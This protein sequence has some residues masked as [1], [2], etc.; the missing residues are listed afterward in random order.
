MGTSVSRGGQSRDT[1]YLTL[2]TGC[3]HG[4]HLNPP[5]R[6]GDEVWCRQC[7]KYRI[8]HSVVPEWGM[9]CIHSTCYYT[10]YYGTDKERAYREASK[11]A[12]HW[13]HPVKVKHGNRDVTTV[14]PDE[15]G[16]TVMPQRVDVS[17]GI[18]DW[19]SRN[20]DHAQ[21]LRRI[22]IRIPDSGHED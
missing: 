16:Q 12:V 13:G 9:R 15:N 14:S 10:R 18:V 20:K 21:S 7:G 1:H 6:K 17:T 19:L 11:H 4:L 2:L 22:N 5:A 3:L 8:V